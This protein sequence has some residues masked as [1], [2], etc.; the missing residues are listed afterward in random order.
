MQRSAT[1]TVSRLFRQRRLARRD[2]GRATADPAGAITVAAAPDPGAALAQE[3]TPAVPAPPQSPDPTGDQAVPGGTLFI[4]SFRSSTVTADPATTGGF[5]VTLSGGMGQTI[6]FADRP[7]RDVA[8]MPQDQFLGT[9]PFP[10]DNPPNAALLTDRGDGQTDIAIVE[11]RNPV[12]DE[13]A[14]TLTYDLQGLA[15]WRSGLGGGMVDEAS[16]LSELAGSFGATHLFIDDC[17]DAGVSCSKTEQRETAVGRYWMTRYF[18][19]TR[20][21]GYCWSW[22]DIMC[23]PCE[24]Y[25]GHGY[26]GTTYDYWTEKCYAAFPEFCRENGGYCHASDDWNSD[27]REVCDSPTGWCS[28]DRYPWN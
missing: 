3:A 7:S 14:E 1:E 2:A 19:W 26:F 25:G 10:D 22:A 9:F 21:M 11:L 13:V 15:D 4:Q 12:V 6:M 24:P 23:Q 28:S 8:A 18:A 20:P 17:S 16:D 27:H 5:R